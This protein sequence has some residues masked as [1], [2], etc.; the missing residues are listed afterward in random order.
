MGM[1]RAGRIPQSVVDRFTA[2]QLEHQASRATSRKHDHAIWQRGQRADDDRAAK[3]QSQRCRNAKCIRLGLERDAHNDQCSAYRQPSTLS[4]VGWAGE[5]VW[6]RIDA[7][8]RNIRRARFRKDR[9]QLLAA[10]LRRR[11]RTLVTYECRTLATDETTRQE[12]VAT[13]ATG[14][15]HRPVMRSQ[16]RV[17]EAETTGG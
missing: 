9:L 3:Q 16:M 15:V 17:I 4:R 11:D 10:P 2:R 8:V 5:T 14:A 6:A 1:R 7:A 12:F 13:V